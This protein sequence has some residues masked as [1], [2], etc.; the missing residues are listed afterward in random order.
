MAA[1]AEPVE[2]IDYQ[3]VV[4]PIFNLPALIAVTEEQRPKV[5]MPAHEDPRSVRQWKAKEWLHADKPMFN[6][7]TGHHR[8]PFL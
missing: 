5:V 8:F 1:T 2:R 3:R 6:S 7:N 4:I